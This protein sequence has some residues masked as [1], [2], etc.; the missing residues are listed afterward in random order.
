MQTQQPQEYHFEFN[1][2]GREYFNIWIVNLL[3]SIVTLGIYSAWA[4][5]RRLQYFYRNT[6]L[7]DASF[8]YHGTPQAILKGRLIAFGL[9][10]A[11]TFAGKFFPLLGLLIAL[12]IG[13]AMPWLIVRSLRFKLY[14][15]SYRGLRFAFA[16]SD[17]DAYRVFLLF[18]ILTGLTLY[19][20]APFTHQRI[21]QYQH[22]N[23]RFGET[24]F[25]FQASVGSFY[26]IYLKFLLMLVALGILAGI[27]FATKLPFL[28]IL[29][30]VAFI[31]IAAYLAVS[32]PNLIWNAT[33]LGEHDLYSRL[34][35]RPYLWISFTNL[36]GIICTLGLFVPFATVRMMRYKLEH[37]GLTAQGDL[38]EFVAGQA[39]PIGAMGEETAEMFD[40]DISL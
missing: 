40:V 17:R 37:M 24:F 16:G 4:K 33:G 20:L 9:L 11:Y 30:P 13:I 6:R 26:G 34:E 39:Q 25:K 27:L 14:N 18:P 3:L 19:L 35:V 5:V 1:A 8:D 31:F 36:L 28:L 23:S 21:K 7:A 2:S 29:L 22:C 12:L 32:L 10:A 38:A 15:S